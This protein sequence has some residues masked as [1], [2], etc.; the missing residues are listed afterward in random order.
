MASCPS[1]QGTALLLA[2]PNTSLSIST[3]NKN[4]PV[5]SPCNLYSM[6]S[7]MDKAATTYNCWCP[8][9]IIIELFTARTH[10]LFHHY[11]LAHPTSSHVKHSVREPLGLLWGF[12]WDFPGRCFL[13][14]RPDQFRLCLR[15]W[16]RLII[17]ML[18]ICTQP[19]LAI[20]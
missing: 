10:H 13:F 2:F 3:L 19:W 14:T 5:F 4:F 8:L 11:Q 15:S 7:N 18:R 17:A 1:N 20:F 16:S 6:K 9:F 12:L